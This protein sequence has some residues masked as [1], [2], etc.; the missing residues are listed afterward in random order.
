MLGVV[1]TTEDRRMDHKK[2][3]LEMDIETLE[4]SIK[5]S[6][7]LLDRKKAQL[8]KLEKEK[9]PAEEWFYTELE[10]SGLTRENCN[11]IDR[12]MVWCIDS[13]EAGQKYQAEKEKEKYGPLVELAENYIKHFEQMK[14]IYPNAD[15]A[16][17]KYYVKFVGLLQNLNHKPEEKPEI[18][19]EVSSWEWCNLA[20]ETVVSFS[21]P[22]NRNFNID[23]KYKLTPIED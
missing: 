23:A 19:G 17:V 13:H 6:Q 11:H 10:K 3:K 9:S 2:F 20:N 16:S 14:R 21:M 1:D 5:T 22:E 7:G 15:F 18:V 8:E 4:L 12:I